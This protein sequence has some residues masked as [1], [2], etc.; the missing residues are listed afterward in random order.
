MHKS[1]SVDVRRTAEANPKVRSQI[2]ADR[3]SPAAAPGSQVTALTHWTRP[4]LRIPLCT[5]ETR[6]LIK[7]SRLDLRRL[8]TPS[9]MALDH[10][11]HATYKI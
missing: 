7:H 5:Y 6:L 3:G 1:E 10:W 2:V 9:P 8:P 11:L 4:I